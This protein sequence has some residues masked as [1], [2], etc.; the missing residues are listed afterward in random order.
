MKDKE[1]KRGSLL[2]AGGIKLNK[3]MGQ[4]FL[5]SQDALKKIIEATE[6]SP[7]DTV[8][9]VGAGDGTLT[10]AIAEKAK[11]VLAV[12]KDGRFS[13]LLQKTVE[14]RGIKNIIVINEDILKFKPE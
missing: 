7:Q 3:L 8:I 12:E 5:I 13:S 6:L 4:N 1:E 14:E 9:E 2:N 10:F 11:L